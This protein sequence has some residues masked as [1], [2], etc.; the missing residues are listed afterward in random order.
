M[1]LAVMQLQPPPDHRGGSALADVHQS[2]LALPGAVH[3][4]AQIEVIGRLPVNAWPASFPRRAAAGSP[5]NV[6]AD[7]FGGGPAG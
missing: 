3:A 2:G 5:R 1:H 6:S 7:A 4:D